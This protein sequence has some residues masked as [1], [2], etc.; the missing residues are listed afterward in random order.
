MHHNIGAPQCIR[1][2]LTAVKQEIDSNKIIVGD[3]NTSLTP[4]DRSSRQKINK[5]TVVLNDALDPVDLIDIYR[6][7]HP[8]TAEYTFFSRARGTFSMIDHMLSHKQVSTNLR[9]QKFYQAL[10]LTTIDTGNQL[11][12]E[13]WGKHKH[14]KL[15]NMLLKNQRVNE[16]IKE[17]I[18]KYLE[19]NKN[20]NKTFRNL[21][22]MAKEVLR[23]KF[24]V[25]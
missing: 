12:E 1:Q 4:M 24:T 3:F 10:F 15:K 25:I 7:F 8:R 16:E 14:M 2:L 22:D 23:E 18:R 17:E 9:R 11:K 6:T 19:T 20:G 21:Q 13:K 5:E